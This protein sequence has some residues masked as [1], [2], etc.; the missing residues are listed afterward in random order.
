MRR[1]WPIILIA[2]SLIA[3]A[4]AQQTPTSV[5]LPLVSAASPATTPTPTPTASLPEH[6]E[7]ALPFT[8]LDSPASSPVLLNGVWYIVV[9]R[10]DSGALNGGWDVALLPDGQAVALRQ[11]GQSDGREDALPP[12]GDARAVEPGRKYCP[13][14]LDQ[15]VGPD[16]NRYI[17]CLPSSTGRAHTLLIQRGQEVAR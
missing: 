13:S 10:V 14:R 5:Y 8:V 12:L 6:A 3:S 4:H 17:F 2:F 11:L 15:A 1:I 16:G 9:Y 7:Y